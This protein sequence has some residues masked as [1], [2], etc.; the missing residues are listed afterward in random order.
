MKIVYT[1][2]LLPVLIARPTTQIKPQTSHTRIAADLPGYSRI[3]NGSGGQLPPSKR[4]NQDQFRGTALMPKARGEAKGRKQE[5]LHRNRSRIRRHESGAEV[6]TRVSDLRLV[7][8]YARRPSDRTWVRSCWIQQNRGKLNVSTEFQS[9]GMIVTAE[10]YFAVSQPSDVVVMENIIRADTLGKAEIIDAKFELLK[11]GSYV[12]K[13]D[14][15]ACEAMP[16]D[17]SK[18]PS[19][20]LGSSQRRA[21]RAL[22]WR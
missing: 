5:G 15:S 9:F 21:D 20:S 18:T 13:A 7:G 11:R 6:W 22:D 4:R 12:F 3:P 17:P 8:D 14:Q 2:L 16:P 19:I 10:P 1:S